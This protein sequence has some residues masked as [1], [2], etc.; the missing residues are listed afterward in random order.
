MSSK[1][2]HHMKGRHLIQALRSGLRMIRV[3]PRESPYNLLPSDSKWMEELHI[4]T[5]ESFHTFG[6]KLRRK[7]SEVD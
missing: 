1:S 4:S 5:S 7:G 6:T 2:H 3:G